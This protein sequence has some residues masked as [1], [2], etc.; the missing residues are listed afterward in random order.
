MNFSRAFPHIKSPH[1]ILMGMMD[2]IIEK[3][4]YYADLEKHDEIEGRQK[5]SFR[6]ILQE[7]PV[8]NYV[9][10]LRKI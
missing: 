1:K 4:R 5:T 3:N 10:V 2:K 9:G 6:K 8:E 7:K